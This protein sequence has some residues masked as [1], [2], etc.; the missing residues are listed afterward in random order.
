VKLV[1]AWTFSRPDAS[2]RVP[3]GSGSRSRR[4]G[5]GSRSGQ[6]R[7]GR[8]GLRAN[9]PGLA[10]SS[11]VAEAAPRRDHQDQRRHAESD[12]RPL[13]VGARRGEQTASSAAAS[14]RGVEATMAMGWSLPGRWK[15]APHSRRGEGRPGRADRDRGQLAGQPS[16]SR[17]AVPEPE[18]DGVLRTWRFGHSRHTCAM[19]PVT[20]VEA[21]AEAT[22]RLTGPRAAATPAAVAALASP[23]LPLLRRA[24]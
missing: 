4:L 23:A 2:A 3:T 20:H 15:R 7:V 21:M 14:A 24:P 9:R 19:R 1:P 13:L 5:K 17:E 6:R 8:A 22:P 18:I 11:G 12:Q 16:S 10:P